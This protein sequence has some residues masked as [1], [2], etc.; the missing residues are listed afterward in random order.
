LA[1]SDFVRRLAELHYVVLPFRRGYY[2]LWASGALLDA[3]TWLKPVVA[4][5]VPLTERFFA[6]YGDIGFLCDDDAALTAAVE[7]LVAV[8]DPGRYAGQVGALRRARTARGIEALSAH[9]RATV[10]QG[11]PGLLEPRRS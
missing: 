5:R 4:T 9:Y 11:F 3:L 10:A 2:D 6:D 1:R 8:P 7:Q